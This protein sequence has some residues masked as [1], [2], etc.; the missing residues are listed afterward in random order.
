[1]TKNKYK[2][3]VING[4][5][6]LEHRLIMEKHLGRKLSSNECVHHRNK[7][8][9]QDNKIK[10]L[11][12]MSREDHSRY[13][14]KP[15]KKIRLTCENCKKKFWTRKSRYESRKKLQEY[16]FCSRS[17]KGKFFLPSGGWGRKGE[18]DKKYRQLIEQGIR[19]GLT[20]YQISKKYKLNHAT[21]YA[22]LRAINP[23]H[24]HQSKNELAKVY[25]EKIIQGL[26]KGLNGYKISKLYK[27]PKTVV[28]SHIGKLKLN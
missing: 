19:E 16:F 25:Q 12:V 7:R 24:I 13:H 8:N 28:Y 9:K 20:G 21:V 1:M 15:A 14:K 17:C 10:H 23:K 6:Y 27:I 5:T 18:F 11:K 4:K 22:H 26:K 2:Y 3:V